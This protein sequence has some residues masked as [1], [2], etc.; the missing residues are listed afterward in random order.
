MRSDFLA[1]AGDLTFERKKILELARKLE[2]DVCGKN[3]TINTDL[4]FDT[5]ERF[6]ELFRSL[7]RLGALTKTLVHEMNYERMVDCTEFLQ[8]TLTW[9]PQKA[10]ELLKS[11]DIE[12]KKSEFKIERE[13]LNQFKPV[14]FE[15]LE[16]FLEYCIESEKERFARKKKAQ[17][18]LQIDLVPTEDGYRL[19]VLC[20]GNGVIPPFADIHGAKLAQTH[21]RASFEGKPGRFSAWVFSIPESLVSFRVVPVQIDG[22]RFCIPAWLLVNKGVVHEKTSRPR[23]SQIYQLTESLE[24]SLIPSD[25]PSG[26]WLIEIKTGIQSAVFLV[27][28]IYEIDE[29]FMRPLS[30]PLDAQKRFLGVVLTEKNPN[31]LSF[32]L[33][34]AYLVYGSIQNNEGIQNNPVSK[35]ENPRTTKVSG[36]I[37]HVF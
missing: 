28:E 24:R 3:K 20:D 12:W 14:F 10:S 19:T 25:P 23:A 30:P 29:V 37:K 32:V 4:F 13:I 31:E 15:M 5:Q 33:N 8:E 35:L 26:H 17:A 34:P 22:K 1:I 2:K 16:V 21:I 36:D 27:D 6:D 11:V 7:E 9:I 18:S